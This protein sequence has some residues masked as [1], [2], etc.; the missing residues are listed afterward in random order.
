MIKRVLFLLFSINVMCYAQIS[1]EIFWEPTIDLSQTGDNTTLPRVAINENYQGLCVWEATVAANRVIQASYWNGTSWSS[2]AHTFPGTDDAVNP[3]VAFNDNNQGVCDWINYDGVNYTLQLSFWD[4]S[5]WSVP[6]ILHTSAPQIFL[7]DVGID[8]NNNVIATWTVNVGGN[9]VV[10]T[11]YWNGSIWDAVQNLSDPLNSTG[12]MSLIMNKNGEALC[13]W[14]GINWPNTFI[15]AAIYNGSTWLAKQVLSDPAV[16][17]Q[18]VQEFYMDIN[19]N[20][21]ALVS[22]TRYDGANYIIKYSFWNK[23]SWSSSSSINAPAG[24]VDPTYGRIALN[25]NDQAVCVY[26]G[27]LGPNTNLYAS[28]WNGSEWVSYPSSISTIGE[29]IGEPSVVLHDNGEAVAIWKSDNGVSQPIVFS[30]YNGSSWSTNQ[31]LSESSSNTG[32]PDLALNNSGRII[33]AWYEEEG[34]FWRTKSKNGQLQLIY[35][36]SSKKYSTSLLLQKD[37]VNKLTW[38]PVENA[39]YYKVYLNSLSNLIFS[40]GTPYFYHHGINKNETYTYYLSWIDKNTSAESIPMKI[41]VSPS[42]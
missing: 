25:N 34:A 36:P 18:D 13:S 4:G 9:F 27:E 40:G 8:N 3:R 26:Y 11:R 10:Q 38:D 1:T 35:S 33:S 7:C 16:L 21:E 6:E 2:S 22:W 24:I 39:G 14:L 42:E 37:Y 5:S 41:T 19:Q 28:F 12:E 29:D 17:P 20:G 15:E 23:A 31:N 30:L 32:T